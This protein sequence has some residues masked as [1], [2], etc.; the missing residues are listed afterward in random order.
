MSIEVYSIALDFTA[1]ISEHQLMNELNDATLP[2]TNVITDDDDCIIYFDSVVIK[3][4]VDIIV[5]AHIPELPTVELTTDVIN[6]NIFSLVSPLDVL[7]V[8][9]RDNLIV[10]AGME[11]DVAGI[12]AP[13]SGNMTGFDTSSGAFTFQ[14]SGIYLMSLQVSTA[15]VNSLNESIHI[16]IRGPEDVFI[17][18]NTLPLRITTPTYSRLCYSGMFAAGDAIKYTLEV[19][20]AN[21]TIDA[22]FSIIKIMSA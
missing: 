13:L 12:W 7:Y 11:N 17:A 9:E 5:A 8:A 10:V 22:I 6:S 14:T 2:C 21:L 18:G 1:G 15:S 4:N 16:K 3:E 19:D 20:S